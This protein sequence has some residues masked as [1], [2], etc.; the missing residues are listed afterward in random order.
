MGK[1]LG[2]LLSLSAQG[3][4]GGALTYS[5]WKGI[6]TVRVKS[7][8]SNPKTTDQMHARALFAGGGKISKASD[9]LGVLAT[10]V[11]TYTPAQQSWISYFVRE[12]LGVGNVNIEA[13]I[14]AYNTGGNATIKG[15]FDDAAT[16]AGVEGVDLDG[17]A[18]TQIPAG[19]LLWA[20][21]TAGYRLGFDG[22][23]VIVTSASEANVFG[24]TEDLTGILP[25]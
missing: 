15:Y 22:A 17:T 13:A 12:M 8:P 14:T 5:N 9:P 24:F 23:S 21:Y 7:N 19:A 11:K 16:Q 25:S 6:S 1:V 18:N 20:A 2:P 4:V 10:D 3:T